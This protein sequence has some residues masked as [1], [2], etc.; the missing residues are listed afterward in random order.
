MW[1]DTLRD[2]KKWTLTVCQKHRPPDKLLL[3]CGIVSHIMIPK[4]KA[5]SS[6][7]NNTFIISLFPV[8]STCTVLSLRCKCVSLRIW[9]F[10]EVQG[11][12]APVFPAVVFDFVF[13][14]EVRHRWVVFFKTRR[15]NVDIATW[16]WKRNMKML[17]R[18][19]HSQSCIKVK[20]GYS[21]LLFLQILD[22]SNAFA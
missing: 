7:R 19:H 10:P 4:L 20:S 8:L 17:N 12:D 9:V 6:R 18:Y 11:K 16:D 13:L 15:R 1:N 2:T 22:A 14:V 21:Q 3:S 5:V